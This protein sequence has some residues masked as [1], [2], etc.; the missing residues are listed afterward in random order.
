M[1]FMAGKEAYHK[2]WFMKDLTGNQ[3][4]IQSMVPGQPVSTLPMVQMVQY[5]ARTG[6]Y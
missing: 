3:V 5:G 1:S 6:T 4:P 2:A